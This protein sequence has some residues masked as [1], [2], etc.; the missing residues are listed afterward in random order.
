MK[1]SKYKVKIVC[2]YR[3]DQEFTIDANET[4]KAYYLFANPDKKMIF[5]SGLAVKGSDIQR[6]EPDFN[7]T[8]GWNQSHLLT[9]DDHN[10][11]S[12]EGIKDKFQGIMA[13]A[14]EIARTGKP[15]ELQTPLIDLK[16]A[17]PALAGRGG[18]S[19]AQQVLENK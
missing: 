19:Y 5:S 10:Q 17:Y 6:I 7:A 3:K 16:G 9:G 15:Q 2:G 1:T 18:S 13:G 14:K 11:L 8:M 4:H 12:R